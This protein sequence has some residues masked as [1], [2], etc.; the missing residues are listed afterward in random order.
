M[1][2]LAA[3]LDAAGCSLAHAAR[4]AEMREK[5][6]RPSIAAFDGGP[7]LVRSRAANLAR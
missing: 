4:T 2:R 3:R 7:P 6:A 5:V 1:A